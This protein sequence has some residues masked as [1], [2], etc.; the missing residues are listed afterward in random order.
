M[1]KRP[2]LF[3]LAVLMC[4]ALAL[5]TA[6]AQNQPH[7]GGAPIIGI[8]GTRADGQIFFDGAMSGSSSTLT[9]NSATFT[10]A[11]TGKLICVDGAGSSNTEGCGTI[12]TY[13]SAHNVTLSF[14]NPNSSVSGKQF[15]YA[16]DDSTAIQNYINNLPNGA[17]IQLPVAIYGVSQGIT[18]PPNIAMRFT[19]AAAGVPNTQ[20]NYQNSGAMQTVHSGTTLWFLTKS[21]SAP[22]LL[23]S[24]NTSYSSSNSTTV[25]EHLSLY[26]GVAQNWDGGG[27]NGINVI[28]WQG[29]VLND[30]YVMNFA[31]D[32]VYIDGG[33]A[34]E[35]YVEHV[36]LKNVFS[37]FNGAHGIH[38]GSG[39]AVP[40]ISTVSIDTCTIE[41]NGKSAIYLNGYNSN[42]QAVSVINSV[43]AWNNVLGVNN[44][45]GNAT[46]MWITGAPT[47]G[48]IRNNYFE[49]N[50][51]NGLGHSTAIFDN[52]M[53]WA[54]TDIS[55]NYYFPGSAAPHF[56]FQTG[57]GNYYNNMSNFA[58]NNGTGA[59]QFSQVIHRGV[60]VSD[61]AACAS[62]TTYSGGGS[63]LCR[64][65][66]N[67]TNWVE[68][69]TSAGCN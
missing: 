31:G 68:T 56:V 10:S 32:G 52:S 2:S 3:I 40:D 8:I 67:G 18:L 69:G 13:N 17:L 54:G 27:N 63:T 36:T 49:V 57:G 44:P 22:G 21:M 6:Y 66:C 47:A 28:N 34:T 23:I 45:E 50:S 46:E 41:V 5:Q 30:I 25:V 35:E 12:S 58:C 16:T 62:G 42:I 19:G 15:V 39:A 11:D 51:S 48:V 65:E 38:V 14:S 33:T 43:V 4:V 64:V 7:G 55:G 26:G 24:G 37:T 59:N 1:M 20:N 60:C 61:A 9:S 53:L 29:L